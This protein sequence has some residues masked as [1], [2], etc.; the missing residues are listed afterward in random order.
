LCPRVRAGA[1]SNVS[2]HAAVNHPM[3]AWAQVPTLRCT[4]ANKKIAAI[5]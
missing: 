2:A 3:N 5:D 4:P 1:Y